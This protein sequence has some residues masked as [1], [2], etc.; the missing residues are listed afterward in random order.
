MRYMDFEKAYKRLNS[1][2]KKAV[3]Q[4]DGPILVIAGPGTGKTQLLSAR[5][6]NILKKTDTLPQNILC[7]T[8]TESGASNMRERLTGFIGQAAYDV[9]IS[10]YHAFG[11]DLIRRFPEY[12]SQTKLQEPVDQL[13]KR[14]IVSEIVEKMSY[15]NSL[16][17]TRHHLGDLMSTISEVKRALLSSDDLVA[18]AEQNS[19]FIVKVSDDIKQIF[20]D[21]TRMPSKYEKA[22]P[23]FE[24]VLKSIKSSVPI[25][26]KNLKFGSLASVA[27]LE[28][29]EALNVASAANKTSALTKWKNSWLAK[30]GDNKF[31]LAGELENKRMS[32]LAEVCKQYQ[33]MLETKGL[34]DFDDMIIRSIE[35]LENNNNLKYTLQEQYQYLLLDEFQDTNAAQLKLVQLLTDNPVNEGKPNVLAVGDDD[36]AIYAFQGAQYSNMLDFYSLFNDV[37]V[38][39]LTENYRSHADIIHTAHSVANQIDTRLHHNFDSMSKILTA[40]NSEL[41]DSSIERHE[42]ISDVAEYDWIATQTEALIKGGVEPSEIAVLAPRHK[43]LEPLVPCLNS[44]DIAV[45]YEKRENILETQ[46]V[47]QLLSMSKLVIALQQGSEQTA[48]ALWAEV[49][50]FEFWNIPISK[51][52]EV[53]WEVNDSHGALTWS[54]ALLQDEKLAP[55]TLLFLTLASREKRETLENMLDYLVGSQSIVPNETSINVLTS[56]FKEYY[57]NPETLLK[58]PEIFYETLSHLTVLRQKLRDHQ[59]TT[60]KTLK[61]T[62]LIHFVQLYEL[63]EERMINTSPYNQ[64]AVAVQLMTVFKAKGLEFKHV[65]IPRCHDD[66]WGESS[67]SNTNKITLPKNLAPI[68]HAGSS[69]DERLRLF[70]VAI[71][72]AK[73]G[74]YLTSFTS[75]YSGKPTKRL[76]YLDE[77]VQADGSFKALSLPENSQTTHISETTTPTIESLEL[78]WQN[79]HMAGI[80]NIQLRDLLDDRIKNY[81][82]SPT[83]LNSFIDLQYAGPEQ[84]FFNTI[85]RFP[86]GPTTDGQF[87]N[88]IHETLEWLQY[89]VN[90]HQI[91]PK[92]ENIEKQFIKQLASKRI[93]ENETKLLQERGISALN[94][95][96]T[97]KAN[98]FTPSDVAE[99]D[100]RNEAVFINGAHLG[101][102]IDRMEVDKT[103]KQIVVVDYKTGKSYDKWSSELK[104]HKY[105][106]QLYCYKILI[107]GSN[108]YKGYQVASGRLEFVEPDA[109]GTINSLRLD[110]KEDE[111]ERTK[112]LLLAMWNCVKK[113]DFPDTSNFEATP[114]G[115]KKFESWLIEN[116]EE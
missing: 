79:R 2:Q 101:G 108:T 36:Q 26:D 27:E 111:V 3:D 57:T 77:Q 88:A 48:S 83:H 105:K 114:A 37:L 68:R 60:A 50:S 89:Q 51:I 15:L 64:N 109:N 80:A 113:L 46:V 44:R 16:K 56:P 4:I 17:Q 87:G 115:V 38:V 12:L 91:I 72:R 74:L 70:F 100:F 110:F 23:Y 1:T 97:A 59:S 43:Y 76:K 52:W 102:K 34:Y 41:E 78:N 21:F 47:S 98:M 6:A 14:E 86:K 99:H 81:Q 30:D 32:D 29:S 11:G 62:D 94:S 7:L 53:S 24:A 55:I 40:A 58:N 82:L 104:L 13:G 42:F 71:T 61:L 19:V 95:Y 85:L 112:Q 20:E 5:V 67:R 116:I 66:V 39:N 33:S 54:K 45:H 96:I 63:A 65:F 28:L 10:T 90:E 73:I 25:E 31:I 84:F 106:Q 35:A 93:G 9:T 49:L 92:K 75:N 103:N 22:A 69:Q 18:I 8:F 107:E